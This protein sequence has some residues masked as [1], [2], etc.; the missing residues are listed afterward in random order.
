MM[1]VPRILITAP[2]SGTGKTMI[3]CGILKALKD[4]YLNVSSFKC[5]PDYIDPMFHKRVLGIDSYNLDTFLCGRDGVRSILRKH[6]TSVDIAVMEGVMGYYDGVAGISTD[7]SAYD[8]ART[9]DTP[10]VLIADCKGMS[11]SIVSLIQGFLNYRPNSYIQ[12]VILNRLSPMMY[13]RMKT[14]I[15]SETEIKVYGYVPIMEDC[16]FE[17]RYLGLRM[18]QELEALDMQIRALGEQMETTIDIDGLLALAQTAGGVEGTSV[19]SKSARAVLEE[20]AEFAGL[21][22][23]LARDE[24]FCFMYRDNLELLETMGAEL[25]PFSPVRDAKLPEN[26]DGLLLYGGYPELYA[27]EL[28]ENRSMR[29]DIKSSLSNG[30]PCIAEC[31]GFM[32]LQENLADEQGATFPMVG[33]LAG[34]SYKTAS[35]R[36]FGYIILSGGTVFG[37]DVGEI[38]AHEFHYYDSGECGSAF[39]ARKPLSE[40]T[41]DCMVSTDTLL[42]GYPHIHYGGNPK[43]A[44]AFLQA[45]KK[46]KSDDIRRDTQTD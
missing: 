16:V 27:Q 17:S 38:P 28:S 14:L 21:R 31:G 18:P 4:R 35:L 43:V 45:C 26:L 20:P 13:G 15:E 39:T 5:G 22:I 23:G 34:G 32:Y 33:A 42:A 12:G 11:V 1:R 2:G 37:Q 40:R 10:A 8:V 41:W 36:R 24:A 44:R 7:A 6:G 25:V 9:T 19:L 29:D 30:L 3:T 46:G